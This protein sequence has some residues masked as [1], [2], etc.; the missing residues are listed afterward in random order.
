MDHTTPDAESLEQPPVEAGAAERVSTL[1]PGA[2]RPIGPPPLPAGTAFRHAGKTIPPAVRPIEPTAP[3]Y[4]DKERL[5]PVTDRLSP[6]PGGRNPDRV[7]GTTVLVGVVSGLLGAALV[8]GS[9]AIA[10][11][12]DRPETVIEQITTPAGPTQIILDG[13]GGATAAAVAE[14][15]VPSIVA[16]EVGSDN[17]DE[18]FTPFASGSGVVLTNSGFIVTNAHVVADA[19]LAQVVLQN[20]AIYDA[21]IIGTDTLTDL[22]VLKI[23]APSLIAIDVGS[24]GGLS[25][26]DLAVAVGNPLGLPGGA[27][28]TVGVVSAFDREVIVGADIGGTLFG[29]LQTDAPITRGSGGGRWSTRRAI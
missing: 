13:A 26:G 22:A 23:D 29:M 8:V 15:V 4:I 21:R 10:G 7:A 16:V 19:D 28:V 17:G 9:L 6:H 20:G 25:I 14:K 24:T 1:E 5:L 27:S 2:G 3:S 12:F 11:V 18:A